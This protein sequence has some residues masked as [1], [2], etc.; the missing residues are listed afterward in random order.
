MSRI[1]KLGRIARYRSKNI[2]VGEKIGEL[3]GYSNVFREIVKRNEF[4]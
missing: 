4:V 3:T 2:V 1:G